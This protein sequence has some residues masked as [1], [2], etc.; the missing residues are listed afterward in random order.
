M[1]SRPLL[2]FLAALGLATPGMAQGLKLSCPTPG[3]TISFDSGVVVVARGKE[4]NDCLMDTVGGPSFRAHALIMQNP[5]PDGS[6][7]SALIASIR[8]ERLWPLQV[9]KRIEAKHSSSKGSW[10]YVLT[11]ARTQQLEG[12]GGALQ[13]TYLIEMT[14]QATNS[15]YRSVSRWWISPKLGYLLRFDFSDSNGTSNRALV[16]K[17][18]N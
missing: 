9:G 13:D 7:T 15:P 6:D 2:T 8:P 1:L 12:P 11:V 14:E 4:G 17:V 10:N 18:S 16:T 3:T 5:G